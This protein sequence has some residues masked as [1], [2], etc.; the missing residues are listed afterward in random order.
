M[1]LRKRLFWS[2]ALAIVVVLGITPP[3]RAESTDS[4]FVG[5][6]IDKAATLTDQ[7]IQAALHDMAQRNRQPQQI[8][9]LIH[10]FATS[11]ARSTDEF[12]KVATLIN[13]E[14]Q[15][16]KQSVIVVGLQW[17]S[18][19]TDKGWMNKVI[20]STLGLGP[21]DNPYIQ[22]VWLARNIGR[23]PARK[24]FLRIQEKF[25][26]ARLNVMAHSLGC[27][28]SRFVLNPIIPDTKTPERLPPYEPDR[29]LNLGLICFCGA[30]VDYD[31]AVRNK[32]V[33]KARGGFEV[34]WLTVAGAA[35]AVRPSDGVLD[36]RSITRGDD[37]MGN[38][39]PRFTPE[40]IEHLCSN[41]KLV[42]DMGAI[43][44]DH[45]LVKYFSAARVAQLA[46]ACAR[47]ADKNA[48]C[49]L[50]DLLDR[51]IAAPKDIKTL[52]AFLRNIDG[53]VQFY[54]LWRL[55]CMLCAGPNHL[56]D[57]T[58]VKFMDT[59]ATNNQALIDRE[60]ARHP[61]AV[62]RDSYWPSPALVQ[63]IL[64]ALP[65]GAGRPQP[66]DGRFP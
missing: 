25:P 48:K 11:R 29:E 44:N 32:D 43:P 58:L 5:V 16:R 57:E 22:K 12:A 34:L 27:D 2:L 35:G 1:S 40:Q 19:V 18:E 8:V 14:F 21:K 42:L 4:P 33:A 10:G 7:D 66:D 50:F 53:S 17:E 47:L 28:L 20:H 55:E 36:V 9:V 52:C 30:D 15:A 13:R 38:R 24:L 31:V 41:R 23:S 26:K 3:A 63:T 46:S 37:A 60:R 54:T 64:D 59:V 49:E 39:F 62:I 6:W 61:C 45:S 51:I 65:G 56:S